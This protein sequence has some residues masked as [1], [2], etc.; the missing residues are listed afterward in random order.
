[1]NK[2]ELLEKDI[3]YL[4]HPY[5]AIE[6]RLS[7]PFPIIKKA[8]GCFLY[9][10]NGYKYLDGIASWWCV[11]FGH[12]HPKLIKVIRK[13]S[14]KLQNV[15]LGGL[16]H[17]P[18]ILLAEKL[19]QITPKGLNHCFFASDGSSAVE[20]ALRIAL[21]YW[22]NRGQKKRKKFI[23]LKDA[24]HGDTLGA[25]GV[26]YVERFHKELKEVV[27][28]NYR[29]ASP[30]CAQCPFGK[31]PSGCQVP[32]F[33][34]METLITKHHHEIAGVIVEPLCQGAAGIRIYPEE[35]LQ[36]LKKICETYNLLL[37]AD[38]IAV[39]FARTGALFACEKAGI[40]PDI[41]IL[42]KGLTGGYLPMSVAIVTDEIYDSFRNGNTFYHGHAF[43]GN[44]LI[45]NL[46]LEAL[47]LYQ[48]E[49][50]VERIQ[51]MSKIVKKETDKL[52]SLFRHSFYNAIGM[53]GMVEI[54]EGEGGAK[55]AEKIAQN[56]LSLGLFIRPLGQTIYLW[57]PL[58]ISPGELR[59]MFALLRKAI[60]NS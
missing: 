58:V 26:G 48:T 57:P 13:Q 10:Q 3:Q 19:Q 28:K 14:K 21:Q 4:W 5:T 49:N 29:A 56:A 36:K 42:G 41:M 16:S 40:H 30:H 12:S 11:N 59:L 9:D 52:G 25:I 8:K 54:H 51:P 44:P 18:G 20:A 17:E 39:G 1:M 60:W 55:R 46:A 45:A 6:T 27:S 35:Y 2:K 7:T 24:Y 34:S 33:A 32:C 22:E 50:I 43:S 37:I 38:E 31:H 47:K 53:I 15:I 23:A